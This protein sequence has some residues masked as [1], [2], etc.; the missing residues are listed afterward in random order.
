MAKTTSKSKQSYYTNYKSSAK[1]KTNRKA[2]LLKTLAAQPANAEQIN[3]A[4]GNMV[5]RRKTPTVSRWSRSVRRQALLFKYF[6][7]KAPLDAFSNN[8]KVSAQARVGMALW[9][10]RRQLAPVEGKVDFSL[11]ARLQGNR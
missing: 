4:L 6:G 5:Y 1:W 7:C 10:E 2:R 8:P 9:Y 11:G 3:A